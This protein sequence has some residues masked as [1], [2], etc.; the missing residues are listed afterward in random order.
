MAPRLEIFEKRWLLLDAWTG[1]NGR[2]H[3]KGAIVFFIK[4]YPD[5]LWTGLKM[6][7]IEPK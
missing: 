2:M 4:K 5:P 6:K 7:L 1:V 3:C